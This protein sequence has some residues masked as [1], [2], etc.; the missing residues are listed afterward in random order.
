MKKNKNI[1]QIEILSQQLTAFSQANKLAITNDS[2]VLGEEQLTPIVTKILVVAYAAEIT[3][4]NYLIHILNPEENDFD[5]MQKMWINRLKKHPNSSSPYFW[6]DGKE[7]T[8]TTEP[9]EPLKI[10]ISPRE[11]DYSRERQLIN[12]VQLPDD[13]IY[14]SNI[15]ISNLFNKVKPVLHKGSKVGKAIFSSTAEEMNHNT[16]SFL[17][18]WRS[19][20]GIPEGS[21]GDP[22]P[23]KTPDLHVKMFWYPELPSIHEFYA[24]QLAGLSVGE[25]KSQA[26]KFKRLLDKQFRP[27]YHIIT[28]DLWTREIDYKTT[29]YNTYGYMYQTWIQR[30]SNITGSPRAY[31]GSEFTNCQI[32]DIWQGPKTIPKS[33]ILSKNIVGKEIYTT[34]F[35]PA[36]PGQDKTIISVRPRRPNTSALNYLFQTIYESGS[37]RS[38]TFDTEQD[39]TEIYNKLVAMTNQI[40]YYLKPT[41][42]LEYYTVKP[43]QKKKVNIPENK[44]FYIK[45]SEKGGKKRKKK[46]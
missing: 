29:F 20:L 46:Y 2:H 36:R 8:S 45:A 24:A 39:A 10:N 19:S 12:Q 38:V 25:Y 37:K 21:Q 23:Y 28:E 22:T 27:F 1:N 13:F 18:I 33:L 16:I 11:Y 34:G 26:Q 40:P 31:Y 3:S 35:D 4:G 17:E 41:G 6:T 9:E 14:F 30:F 7:I 15:E 43:A 42:D 32:D 44:P 5:K